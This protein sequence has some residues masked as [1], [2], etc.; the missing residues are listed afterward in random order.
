MP[1]DREIII[2]IIQIFLIT[3]IITLFSFMLCEIS[4]RKITEEKMRQKKK[5]KSM[6][7]S[8]Q[9]NSIKKTLIIPQGAILLWSWRGS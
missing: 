8:I 5:T 3:F 4:M 6:L 1:G 7:S 2:I 9:F